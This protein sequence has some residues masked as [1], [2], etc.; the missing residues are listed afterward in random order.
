M[1]FCVFAATWLDLEGIMLSEISQTNK[2]KTVYHL[3]LESKKYN[4]Q[5]NITKKKQIHKY[6]E[7]SGEGQNRSRRLIGT[8]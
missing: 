2:D 6:R 3:H 8:K 7:G 4:K 1:K 5:V